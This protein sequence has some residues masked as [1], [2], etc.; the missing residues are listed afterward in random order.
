[1]WGLCVIN[2]VMVLYGFLV[3]FVL[4][5]LHRNHRVNRSH[6]ATLTLVGWGLMSTSFASAGL[7]IALAL[8]MVLTR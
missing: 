3:S 7:M 5:S 2:V 1:M 8:V 6:G 4:N